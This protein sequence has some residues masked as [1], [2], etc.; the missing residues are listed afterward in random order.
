M[1]D[2]F[3]RRFAARQRSGECYQFFQRRQAAWRSSE[4]QRRLR[5]AHAA[6]LLLVFQVRP[7]AL[8]VAP[9]LVPPQTLAPPAAPDDALARVPVSTAA[10]APAGGNADVNRILRHGE[11]FTIEVTFQAS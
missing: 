11:K 2:L 6:R 1:V 9:G 3:R 5:S 10:L 8:P 7:L 4:I